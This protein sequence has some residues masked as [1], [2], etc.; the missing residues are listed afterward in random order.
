MFAPLAAIA[1][2]LVLS[3]TPETTLDRLSWAYRPI[4]V[5]AAPGDPRLT[6]QLARFEAARVELDERDNLVIVDT[7]AAS[8][9]R[10][11]FRPD[12][13]TVVL[14]GR[15]GGEKFRNGGLVRPEELEE[16]IDTMPMRLREMREAASP[17]G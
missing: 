15:D 12:G 3:A 5:F 14:V 16:L 13:F 11:R 1:S 7:L 2:A 8:A 17:E 10:R 4:L 9:L 6:E